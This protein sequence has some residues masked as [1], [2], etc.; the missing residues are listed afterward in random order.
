MSITP[1]HSTGLLKPRA[2]YCNHC[3]RKFSE[4]QPQRQITITKPE[5][6]LQITRFGCDFCCNILEEWFEGAGTI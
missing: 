1:D 3:G 5:A 4:T 6:G 2:M